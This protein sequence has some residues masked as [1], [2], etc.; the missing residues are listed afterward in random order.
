M[1]LAFAVQTEI[2]FLVWLMPRHSPFARK[3]PIT[4]A[5]S[6][7]ILLGAVSAKEHLFTVGKAVFFAAL[8][9]FSRLRE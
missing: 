5:I 8:Q 7:K 4:A 9:R 2:L 1:S 6:E 3:V